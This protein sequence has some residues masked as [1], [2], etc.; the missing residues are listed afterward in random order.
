[1]PLRFLTAGESHGQAL[2]VIVE[3]MPSGLPIKEEEINHQLA[4]RQMGYGRGGRMKIEQDRAE[5]LSGV[6]AGKTLGSPIA[7]KINNKDW[8][9]WQKVMSSKAGS[10]SGGDVAQDDS[11]QS[12]V[13]HHPRPGHADLPG[14]MK[15]DHHDLRNILERASARE[16][17]GRVAAGAIARKLLSEFEIEIVGHLVDLGGVQS[18]TDLAPKKIAEKA[19]AS[20]LRTVDSKAEERMIAKIDEAKKNGDSLGGIFEIIVTG[21]PVGLGSHV[22]WDRKLDGELARAV[23]SIQAIKGVEIG[24]GFASA[25]HF[26]SEVHDEIFYQAKE[27]RFY[28]KTNNAGGL[29]GGMTNGENLVLRAVMKPLST[30]YRPLQSVNIMTKE[31]YQATVE[32]TDITAVPAASVIGENVVAF[33]LAQ[34]FLEK[35]GSDS[36][37]EL[38]RNF[39]GFLK[40]CR[41]F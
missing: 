15:Y 1:M 19:E 23:M 21:L 29:E 22:Q 8:D 35:F 34:A 26:G 10:A 17:A 33:T 4:R 31:P 39:E 6:R 18:T 36:L 28:R 27:K 11:G 9:N 20:P 3:G 38:R 12:K 30:L 14:G 13:V 24:M 5:I 2:I 25:A 37:K 7:L 32:R 41:E 40:Q 16:T